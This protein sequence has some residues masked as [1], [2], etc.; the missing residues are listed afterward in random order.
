MPALGIDHDAFNRLRQ[1]FGDCGTDGLLAQRIE[2]DRT[3]VNRV[4]RG[5]RYPSNQFIAGVLKAFGR[6]WF[7]ELFKVV[8]K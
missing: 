7:A 3:T 4:L 2:V 1:V 8:D 6:Q 5:Q